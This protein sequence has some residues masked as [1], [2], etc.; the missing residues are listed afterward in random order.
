[1]LFSL[2]L[3]RHSSLF[4][5]FCS[6]M[7][8][9]TKAI[10]LRTIKY[11][12]QKVIVDL[13]TETDG[14]LSVVA[15]LPKSQ[16][17][18][19]RKPLFQPLTLLDIEYDQRPHVSLFQ[20]RDAALWVPYTLLRMDPVKNALALFLA[21]FLY[22]ATRGEQ[23]NVALFHYVAQSMEW[24]DAATG[25]LANFHLVMMMRLTRFV[26]FFPNTEDY[27][28]GC[29]FDLQNGCYSV[30]MP[31]HRDVIPPD[32]AAHIGTLMRLNYETMHLFQMTRAERNRCIDVIT[33][34]Y[35]LHVPGFPELNSTPVM[36]EMFER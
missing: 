16:K 8:R 28:P 20:L 18:K 29:F 4:G 23:Q 36:R 32:E 24:L 33:D 5:Y 26:G 14:R 15:R 21:E 17:G 2:F 13:F 31:G 19:F 25:S 7:L 3:C 30:E 27:R 22:H 1:M 9:K 35:R 10:V 12:E 6:R 11:G 34:Y